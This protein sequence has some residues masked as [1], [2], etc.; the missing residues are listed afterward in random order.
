MVWFSKGP[1]WGLAII[2]KR[3]EVTGKPRYLLQPLS[4]PLRHAKSVIKNREDDL[5]PWLA[6]SVPTT[7][8]EAINNLTFENVPWERVLNGGF[9]RGDAEVDG[10]IL[11]AKAIDISYS[12]FGRLEV[13]P[14]RPGETHWNAMFLGAEKIWVGEPVRLRGAGDGAQNA[15]IFVMII[16]QLIEKVQVGGQNTSAVT[17]V[18][19][20]Y[21]FITTTEKPLDQPNYLPIRMTADLRFRNEAARAASRNEYYHWTLV[22]GPARRSI[23]DVK[24]RWYETRRLLPTLRTQDVFQQDLSRGMTS[25]VGQWMNGRGDS[26]SFNGGKRKKNRKDTLGK[27]VPENFAISKGLDA[28]DS[29][30]LAYDD[31]V[32]PDNGMDQTMGGVENPILL[33]D[34]ALGMD[35][36]GLDQ[37]MNLDDAGSGFFTD[38]LS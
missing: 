33:D 29:K 25:D 27:S 11:A 18:G 22:E 1:A 23:G 3:Q 30:G 35:A 8:H 7:T 19:D 13:T 34:S 17:L 12:F 14:S 24:G 2:A 20:V 16:H 9:G 5:R 37:F 15:D 32:F 31:N 28:T 10:S 21:K 36:D 6:W 26:T 38:T 4:N